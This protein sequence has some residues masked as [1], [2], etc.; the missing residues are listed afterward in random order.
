M[1]IHIAIVVGNVVANDRTAPIRCNLVNGV[2]NS[3]K[4]RTVDINRREVNRLRNAFFA[5][6]GIVAVERFARGVCK[7]HEELEF[8]ARIAVRGNLRDSQIARL[9][10]IRDDGQLALFPI[11]RHARLVKRQRAIAV[12]VHAYAELPFRRIVDHGVVE[13]RLTLIGDDFLRHI[14]D[15]L[16]DIGLIVRKGRER[17]RTIGGVLRSDSLSV[18]IEHGIALLV[19]QTERELAILQIARSKRLP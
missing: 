11:G 17:H 8:L 13:A 6:E 5:L 19:E 2:F 16:A 3:R 10:R 7:F 1:N 18:L 9:E 15:G 12:V 14:R 4:R